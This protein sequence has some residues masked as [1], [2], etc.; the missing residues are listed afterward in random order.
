MTDWVKLL[1]LPQGDFAVL[2][3]GWTEDGRPLWW[4]DAHYDNG[5]VE[6]AWS[7]RSRDEAMHEK[8]GA[9]VVYHGRYVTFQLTEVAVSRALFADILERIDRLRPRPV[10][11]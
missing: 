7:G 2:E 5:I 6:M 3:H 4:I 8:V 10:P 1:N 9:K 11:T